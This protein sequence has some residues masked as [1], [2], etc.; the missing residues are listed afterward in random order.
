MRSRLIFALLTGA[1]V[2]ALC[3]AA[4]ALIL[5]PRLPWWPLV[6]SAIP[7]AMGL[8]GLFNALLTGLWTLIASR[9]MDQPTFQV[10]ALLA[11]LS[12]MI[13]L[14]GGFYASRLWFPNIFEL[15]SLVFTG[16]WTCAW[17][18]LMLWL[19]R[20]CKP[21][22]SA[23][24]IYMWLRSLRGLAV[25]LAVTAGL[26]L[27][28]GY[29]WKQRHSAAVKANTQAS[30]NQPNVLLIVMDTTRADRL[31]CYGYSR[32]TTPN[33]DRLAQEGVLFEQ[34]SAPAP[35]TFP[36][37]ASLF[38]GLYPSQ[39][40]A[41]WLHQRLDDRFTTLAELLRDHG[42]H[43]AG[44]SNNA[45]VS[46][47]PNLDQGF[48]YFVNVWESNRLVSRLAIIRII[49]RL[50]RIIKKF[51]ALPKRSH[52]NAALT[53]RHIKQWLDEI[54]D[55]RRPFFLFI[56]YLEPHFTYE[57]PEPF[58][59][60]FL[61]QENVA[62]AGRLDF[63]ALHRELMTEPPINPDRAT[64]AA[65]NDLYDGEV[66]YLDMRVGELLDELRARKLLDN[67]VVLVTA[68]HGENIGDHELFWH[69]YCVYETLLRVPLILHY[70]A[71]LPQGIQVPQPVSLVDVVP[72]LMTLLGIEALKLRA[73]LPGQSWV[74]SPLAVRDERPIL[75][76][77][78][79][80]WGH[81]RM[82]KKAA[83]RA[84]NNATQPVYE[85][86]SKRNLKSLRRGGLKFILASDGQYELYDLRRDPQE[87]DNL[88]AKFPELAKRMEQ[89]LMQ[90]VSSIKP[91]GSL[92]AVKPM[93][94]ATQQEL[95]A[96]GY[97]Q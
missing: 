71:R 24:S 9:R 85:R 33:L 63:T 77:Y 42:Y 52:A 37:H 88:V 41:G 40:G 26:S 95:R 43:T 70:P 47:G 8:Y 84:H 29:V 59:N 21:V 83:K 60:R 46:R 17:L 25:L 5:L 13:Y 72:T 35:W 56:N 66:A 18:V 6:A 54:R 34:A 86:Y 30:V 73:A 49:K 1:L 67:T 76:E 19:A 68:D 94:E 75:A 22:I 36:S 15:S 31:S 91:V 87:T 69:R 7:I 79:A 28:P 96:L 10:R 51:G 12:S 89:E 20:S 57:P 23:A 53:N 14:F 11:G 16:I 64:Q 61:K 38:T 81:R 27:V 74:S 78:E 3:G 92:E 55:P 80:P 4:E 48:E 58:R 39:H 32:P 97:L 44:F 45:W 2:G 90:Y 50:D 93:D 82:P 65:L 62:V